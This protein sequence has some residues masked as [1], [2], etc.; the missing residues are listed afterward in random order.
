M[1]P[2]NNTY[3]R[4]I[5]P[6]PNQHHSSA[7]Q[8]RH[9]HSNVSHKDLVSSVVD[10]M[11]VENV[12]APQY[13]NATDAVLRLLLDCLTGNNPHALEKSCQTAEDTTFGL[14]V[15]SVACG[16]APGCQLAL[17]RLQELFERETI[18]EAERRYLRCLFIRWTCGGRLCLPYIYHPDAIPVD[19]SS[20]S[21]PRYV[22]QVE[23]SAQ[24]ELEIYRFQRMAAV[25]RPINDLVKVLTPTWNSWTLNSKRVWYTVDLNGNPLIKMWYLHLLEGARF[26]LLWFPSVDT[27]RRA[28]PDMMTEALRRCESA[29]AL[30]DVG[31][32]CEH[33]VDAVQSEL[34]KASP[35]LFVRCAQTLMPVVCSPRSTTSNPAGC[36][37]ANLGSLTPPCLGRCPRVSLLPQRTTL[38]WTSSLPRST[39]SLSVPT[40]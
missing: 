25:L 24:R 26:D 22:T 20:S 11:R 18:Y 19:Y 35:D 32:L 29:R 5:A 36:S 7:I 8:P 14:L 9:Q 40:T 28:R 39:Q 38:Q 2:P 16:Y 10:R 37:N 27:I 6:Q 15:A 31:G 21:L 3:S 34:A 1:S 12:I 23:F 17:S 30:H 13:F 4:T 33:L